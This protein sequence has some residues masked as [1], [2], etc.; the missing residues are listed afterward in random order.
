LGGPLALANLALPVLPTPPPATLT[1]LSGSKVGFAASLDRSAVA[2]G[3]DGLVRMELVMKADDA[4]G[5]ARVAT[6]F[7]VV[8]DR[9]GSMSGDRIYKAR[10][11]VL[12]LID[13]LGQHDRLGLVIFDQSAQPLISLAMADSGNKARWREL[14]QGIEPG[15]GT[16]LSEGLDQ[17]LALLE[18]GRSQGRAG[19]VLLLSDGEANAGDTSPEGLRARGQRAARNEQ[20]LSTIGIG[21]GFNEYLMAQLADAG[22]GNFHYLAES[23][24]LGAIIERE[25]SSTRS[26]VATG[27]R[28]QVAP[29]QGVELV[30]AGGYPL[31]RSGQ[32]ASFQPGSLFSGQER[33]IWLTLRVPADQEQSVALGQVSLAYSEDGQSRVLAPSEAL[34]VRCV[35]D[36]RVALAAIDKSAWERGVVQEEWGRVQQDVAR[37]VR[38]GKRN[39]ALGYLT[40]YQHKQAALNANVGSSA[41]DT[42]LNE[43]HSLARQVDDAFN[44][45]DQ[46]GKQN[47]FSKGNLARSRG[48]RRV[49][50]F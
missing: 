9:S 22:T 6:D 11:A 31:E 23:S 38:E 3:G 36:E 7:V 35:K 25:L 41:V 10:A 33:R 17:G 28:V 32:S 40:E 20:V 21:E 34:A 49:G 48:S 46:A 30:D 43:S 45:E 15:G 27:L 4:A 50:S 24:K 5:A 42:T 44:G 14:V 8:L 37:A 47:L 1:R 18:A 26:T 12:A 13:Q 2:R 19:R 39:D 29:G 16:N